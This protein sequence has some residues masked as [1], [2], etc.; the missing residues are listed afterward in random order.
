M[1]TQA[2]RSCG[3]PED[4]SVGRRN[5]GLAGQVELGVRAFRTRARFLFTTRY[6]GKNIRGGGV[7]N[8][9]SVDS[10][11]S[12]IHARTRGA[13]LRHSAGGAAWSGTTLYGALVLASPGRA[14]PPRALVMNATMQPAGES[15]PLLRAKPA[16]SGL[17][18]TWTRTIGASPRPDASPRAPVSPGMDARRASSGHTTVFVRS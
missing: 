17:A 9:R 3:D 1:Y 5:D 13:S 7:D 2:S 6:A 18:P 12:S 15:A 14:T 16:T 11:I 4:C 10:S 8:R